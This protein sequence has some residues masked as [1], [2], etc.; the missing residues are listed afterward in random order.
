MKEYPVYEC[1]F[2]H[3]E[4]YD[5]STT[6]GTGLV[7]PVNTAVN[8]STS[9]TL[10]W[11]AVPG[12]ISYRLQI[13]MDSTFTSTIYDDSTR[14]SNS[15]QIA[16]LTNGT[17]YYW[18]VNAKNSGGTSAYSSIWSFTTIAP[19]VAPVLV[20]P[21]NTAVNIATSPTLIWNSVPEVNSYR[22]QIPGT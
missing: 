7:T 19:P 13:S 22:L 20:A 16:G 6:R 12:A 18:R 15:Q 1:I 2:Q 3:M 9:P 5:N 14:K 4:F 21:V 11:N 10:A 17:N 8:I